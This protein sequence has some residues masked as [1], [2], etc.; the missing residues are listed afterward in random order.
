MTGVETPFHT[1]TI[2]EDT[3]IEA[4]F[5]PTDNYFT[6]RAESFEFW[7]DRTD[8]DVGEII[9]VIQGM[10]GDQDEISYSLISGNVDRDG[11]GNLLLG[12]SHEGLV[13]VVDPDEIFLSSGDT[14]KI[15]ISLSDHGGKNSLTDGTIKIRPNF[16]LDSDSLGNSWYESNWLGF[17]LTTQ[18]PWIYHQHLGWLFFSN[19]DHQGYWFWD[20][21]M[22]D[23]LWTDPVFFPWTFSY[24]N[25]SWYYFNLHTEKVR[26]FDHNIQRWRSRP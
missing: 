2:V 8:Y 18:T 22:K 17:Y 13:S 1:L 20:S 14:F 6:P 3:V 21:T 10:D 26:F 4:T 5:S 9:H 24:T 12:V 23:W 7:V 25:S 11:D 16:V 19:M 15:V